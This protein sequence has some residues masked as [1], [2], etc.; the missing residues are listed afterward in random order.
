MFLRHARKSSRQKRQNIKRKR[1]RR[2]RKQT[3][4]NPP[5]KIIKEKK[6]V[7]PNVSRSG[8]SQGKNIYKV[9]SRIRRKGQKNY[10]MGKIIRRTLQRNIGE[11]GQ[12]ISKNRET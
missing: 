4:F 3:L 1:Q 7:C 10:R 8:S 9:K 11:K 6:D 12:R 5:W 2:R